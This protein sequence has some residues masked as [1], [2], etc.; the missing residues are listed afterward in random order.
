LLSCVPAVIYTRVAHSGAEELR[1]RGHRVFGE[2]IGRAT[3]TQMLLCGIFRRLLDGD[4]I[5]VVDDIVTAM[6]SA[7]PRIWP[8]KITR[9]GAAYGHA[10]FGMG[11]TFVASQ[12]ALFGAKRFQDIGEVL[13]E[14]QRRVVEQGLADDELL[15]I[16][17]ERIA[18]FRSLYADPRFDGLVGQITKRGRHE[19]PFMRICLQAARL[20]RT[21]LDVEPHVFVAIV[22]LFLDMGMTPYDIGVFAMLL[23]FHDAVGNASEGAEQQPDVLQRLPADAVKYVGRAPRTS[24]RADSANEAR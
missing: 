19:R 20:A 8:F 24:M 4:D 15:A 13:I 23:L 11:T 17:R 1:F 7:D 10:T 12:G 6:S 3:T 2:L 9:L 22:A 5:A 14:L 21:E 16:L 18:G